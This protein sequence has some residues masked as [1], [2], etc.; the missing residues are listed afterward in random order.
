MDECYRRARHSTFV[1]RKDQAKRYYRVTN[2]GIK[3]AQR[4]FG[5]GE[6]SRRVQE[7]EL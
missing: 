4:A 6:Q 7:R 3:W 1:Q 5:E 2:V